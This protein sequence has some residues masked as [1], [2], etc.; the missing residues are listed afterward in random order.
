M[1]RWRSPVK[2]TGLRTFFELLHQGVAFD[3]VAVPG[4]VVPELALADLEVGLGHHD[5]RGDHVPAGLRAAQPVQQPPLLLGAEHGSA[6]SWA[7]AWLVAWSLRYCRVS[8][9]LSRARRPKSSRRYIWMCGP[10]GIGGGADRHVLVERLVA[11]GQPGHERVVRLLVRVLRDLAGEVVVDLVVVEG[12]DPG[13]VGVHRPAG[14]GRCGTGRTGCGT[15][16]G[17]TARR[18][19]RAGARPWP[20]G[21]DS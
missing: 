18:C 11:G 3:L 16:P 14:P 1:V 10:F 5:L 6:G 7:P 15:G 20:A 19:P 2:T 8:S 21:V 12:D 9:T 13:R 17:C 4:V